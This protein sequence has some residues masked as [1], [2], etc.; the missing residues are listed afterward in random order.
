[1]KPAETLYSYRQDSSVPQFADDKPIIVFDG[2]CVLCSGWFH[3]VL[4]HDCSEQFRFVIAQS[5][6]GQALYRHYGLD[7]VDFE[8]NMVIADGKLHVKLDTLAAVMGRLPMPWPLLATAIRLLP[9]FFAR[10]LYEGIARNRYRWFGRTE[11]C[12]IPS[13]ELRSRFIANGWV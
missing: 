3:F 7:A 4:R 11:T 5:P 10:F 8:T 1:M 6:L 13:P 9:S 2:V 12:L